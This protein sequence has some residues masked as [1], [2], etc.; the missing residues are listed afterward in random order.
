[1]R[2]AIGRRVGDR[3]PTRDGDGDDHPTCEGSSDGRSSVNV[4]GIFLD[5]ERHLTN[6]SSNQNSLDVELARLENM[7]KEVR[8]ASLL[9]SKPEYTNLL[10]ICR[11]GEI[12][13]GAW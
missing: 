5:V 12:Q 11:S 4:E 7:Y 13:A 8:V 2:A 6:A 3:T 1:M 10:E 9:H